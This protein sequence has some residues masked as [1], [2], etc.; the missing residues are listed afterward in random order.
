[1]AYVSSNNEPRYLPLKDFNIFETD[2]GN[3]KNIKPAFNK[4]D[5]LLF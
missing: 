5:Q 3:H 2:T 1:M 4:Q